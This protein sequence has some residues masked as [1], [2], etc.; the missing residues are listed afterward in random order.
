MFLKRYHQRWKLAK[1]QVWC[2]LS[3]CKFCIYI[4]Q[5]NSK[6]TIWQMTIQWLYVVFTC[7]LFWVF[8]TALMFVWMQKPLY[9]LFVFT[10]KTNPSFHYVYINQSDQFRSIGLSYFKLTQGVSIGSLT[11]HFFTNVSQKYSPFSSLKA[12]KT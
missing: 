11:N 9:C 3:C 1:K 4:H 12:E 5:V 2:P 10:H 7:Y 6:F 8:F